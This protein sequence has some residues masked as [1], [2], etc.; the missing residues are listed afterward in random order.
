MT[1]LLLLAIR[2]TDGWENIPRVLA[3]DIQVASKSIVQQYQEYF[4]ASG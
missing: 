1:F 2:R 3:R 4:A